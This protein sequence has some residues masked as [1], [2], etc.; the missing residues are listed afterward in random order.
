MTPDLTGKAVLVTGAARG[1]GAETARRLAGRGARLAL[2]GLE[3]ERLREL[4]AAL[5]PAHLAVEADVTDTDAVRDAV[6]AAVT[7]L[8]GLDVVVANAGIANHATVAV[9]PAEAL[10]RTIDVNLAGVVRTISAALPHL[11]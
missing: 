2:A 9:S 8:G 3:P 7:H 1:I 4:A 6:A 11:V 5:G 10:L